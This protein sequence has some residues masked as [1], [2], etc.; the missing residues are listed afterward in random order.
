M[1]T[2]AQ[3]VTPEQAKEKA[4][5]F[6]KAN[7]ARTGGKRSAPAASALKTAVVFDAKDMAGQPY[8][9]AVSATQHDGFVLVSGDERFKAVLGYSDVSNFDEQNMPDNMRVFLQGYIDEMKYLESINYQ[10]TKAAPRRS[11]S[12]VG[13]LMTTTW[14]QRAPYN[15]QCPLD[16]SQRSATGCVATAMAQVVNYHIQNDHGP[17]ATIAEIP[18]YTI[19]NT[20]ITVSAIP[21]G[22]A[23]PSKD[24]LLNSYANNAGT[25]EQK[26]AVAQLMYYCGT[27]V[28]M[29]YAAGSSGTQTAYVANALINYFGFDNT[30]RFVRR[31]DYSYADWVNLIYNEVAASRPVVLGAGRAAGGHAFVADGFDATNTLFHI[32]WG[33]GGYLD[34][35]F[36][37]S[38]LN[39]DD[40]G[41]TGAAAGTDGYTIDQQAIVGI[42]HV[43]ASG[44]TDPASLTMDSYRVAG[45][46]IHFSAGNLTGTTN[47][48]DIGV[49]VYDG[50]SI[51]LFKLIASQ[52][53]S[54]GSAFPDV[55]AS[56]ICADFANQTRKLIPMSRVSE[57]STW[58]PGADPDINYFSAVYDAYGVP[59]LTAHPAPNFQNTTFS[60]P[61]TVFVNTPQY[62]NV[63]FTNNGEEYYGMAYFFVSTDANNKGAF[64]AQRGLGAPTGVPTSVEFEWTPTSATT[65]YI[66]AT[67]DEA[68]TNVVG[69]TSVTATTDASLAGKTL[70]IVNYQLE[71]QDDQSFQIDGNGTRS[72]DVYGSMLKGKVTIKN[73]SASNYNYNGK[74]ITL[75]YKKWN[76]SQF[77]M[78]NSDYDIGVLQPSL[79]GG[80]EVTFDVNRDGLES[81]LYQIS[82][83]TF[84]IVGGNVQNRT[85]LDERYTINLKP[86]GMTIASASDWETFCTNVNGGN[87][88]SGQLVKMTA[89]ITT[90]TRMNGIFKGVFDG[91]GHTL[92]I[93]ISVTDGQSYC[94]PFKSI[95]GA[96]I[97]NLTVT[98]SVT[99]NGQFTGGLVG[100]MDGDN[101][102]IE[103]CVVNANVTLNGYGGGVVGSLDESLTIK[104]VVY[105]GTITQ[106]KNNLTGGII[107]FYNGTN[108]S[109]TMTNCLFKGTYSGPSTFHPIGMKYNTSSPFSTLSCTNCF[110]TANPQNNP[111]AGVVIADGTKVSQ[112]SLGQGISILSGSTCSFLNEVYHYGTVT[113][114]YNDPEAAV[115]YSL[116][117]TPLPG[118][119]FTIS[120]DDAAFDDG[121][122]T[123]T[124]GYSFTISYNLDGGTVATPNPT[125]YT[126][127]SSDITLNNPTRE[128]WTFT[129]WTGTGLNGAQM[130]V[131]IAQGSTGHR[132]YTATWTA[133]ELAIDPSDGAYVINNKNDWDRFCALVN[134]G[135]NYWSKTVKLTADIGTAQDPVTTK[136]GGWVEGNFK[137][138]QA[139]FDGQGHTLTVNYFDGAPFQGT[140]NATIRNLHVAGNITANSQFAAG[141]VSEAHYGLTIENC[142]SS[143]AIS[144]SVSGDGTH[145]GLVGVLYHDNNSNVNITGCVFDGSITTTNGTNNCGGFIGWSYNSS[146][147]TLSN[148]VLAPTSVSS[149]MLEKTFVRYNSDTAPT[150][151]NTY[152]VHVDNLTE[153]QGKEAHTITAGENV[154]SVA[155]GG[156]ATEYNVSG[157]TAYEGSNGLKYGSTVYAGI[158][159]AVDLALTANPP[160]NYIVDTYT[161]SAGSITT[162]S[163]TSA[164]L[165]MPNENVTIG[166]T[167]KM[168]ELNKDNEN[169]YLVE[170]ANDW[171]LFCLRVNNGLSTYS[172]ATVKLTANI[173]TTQDPVTTMAGVFLYDGDNWVYRRFEGTF[174]GQGNT[175]T[176]GYGTS[177]NRFSEQYA[178]PFRYV[179]GA[180]IRNLHVAGNIYTSNQCAT[181]FVGNVEELPITLTNCRS[182]V[183]INCNYEYSGL[184]AGFVAY[185]PH[186]LNGSQITGC[187]FDGSFTTIQKDESCGGFF[188][189]AGGSI[190]ITNCVV[191][192]G[193]VSAGMLSNTFGYYSETATFNNCYYVP[194]EN[195]PTTQGTAAHTIS[196]GTNVTS[197]AIS[198]T[199]TTTYNVSGI[200][201]YGAGKGIMVGNDVCAVNGDEVALTLALSQSG[202]TTT[203]TASAGTLN[204]TD[205]THATLT[206]PNEN[207][208]IGAVF[209][210]NASYIDENGIAQT[211][212]ANELTSSDE[213]LASG[214]YVVSEDVAFSNR[215][216]V[217]GTVNLIL[218]D[219]KT[220]TASAG[221]NVPENSSL[222]I[223]GQSSGTGKL[224]AQPGVSNQAAI[225]GGNEGGEGVN[226]SAGTITIYGGKVTATSWAGAG[227]GGG[228]TYVEGGVF[229]GSSGGTVNIYGGTVTAQGGMGAAIGGS[230]G[231]TGFTVNIYGGTI[232][233]TSGATAAA[234]GGGDQSTGGTVNIHGGNI[235]ANAIDYGGGSTDGFGIG[236]GPSYKSPTTVNLSWT[237]TTDRITATSYNGTV[238]IADGKTL[239]DGANYY[240]G[241]LT[242]EQLTAMATQTLQPFVPTG[243]TL[244]TVGEDLTATFD[245]TSLET[246]NIPAPISVKRVTLNRTFSADKASTVM[247]PFDYTCNNN[248]GGTFYRFVGVEKENNTWV[249]TM[250]ATGDGANNAG[251][252]TANMPYLFMP[253]GTSITFTIPSEGVTLNTTGGGNKQTADAGSHWTFKGT[254]AYKEWIAD[255]ANS[256]EI[257]SVYGFA[258][259]QKEGINVGDFV[260]V[261]SGAKI[262]P[263]CAYLI[264]ND[265]PNSAP[266][267]RATEELPQSIV[268][269]L[270]GANGTV[271][272]IGTLDTTTGD[273]TFDSDA[274]YDMS[275][276]KLDGKPTTKGLY[277]NNGRKVVIK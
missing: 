24:L 57:T 120:K 145:G 162:N 125:T 250:Q 6:L 203:Y 274:W 133:D 21:S 113:L 204:Q 214:W 3:H 136:A 85:E 31:I 84:E 140:I 198:T 223:W 254:Y 40:A 230:S 74:Y 26:A 182:S 220:L 172:G 185:I 19:P 165:T 167:W 15:N 118:N 70:A 189:V 88:Y 207:V 231:C 277:I 141:F 144:S 200:K 63:T 149:G 95:E 11:M 55:A 51:T 268:V 242:S 156:T 252:L 46:D 219:G 131:T 123:I 65:Y 164:T 251:T 160:T 266:R 61:G 38:V 197:L 122:A 53:L 47:S 218:A 100:F 37:L 154:S 64:V 174:D 69:S 126:S 33:W 105:G 27:S 213:A 119:S 177:E 101:N 194:V 117:G 138:F 259:V 224:T 222:I 236:S 128:G 201:F 135:N 244:A 25:D 130:T 237:N 9:Y 264:W 146:L 211:H 271:T 163:A 50:S 98:G 232:N 66:W 35:Y 114:G 89:D 186:G 43:G 42:Q 221:V 109:L 151:T 78:L 157:I 249:A 155:I 76:G 5:Q 227:I 262:R 192:P 121:T 91:G 7:Y 216:V 269:K 129:G 32:N 170:N 241:T 173:G 20:T 139:S 199:P 270:I 107:G 193:S 23:I 267:H 225:G 8:L 258:G 102:L 54:T 13:V 184:H 41:Q 56:A 4:S 1:G 132:H 175:L 196:A 202:Y 110:Y 93:T 180:T 273:V 272:G 142:R 215:I 239:T 229:H 67:T 240:S 171:D 148:S 208:T 115:T 245:G 235:T 143:V 179:K 58:I 81:G 233:A 72:I 257:G 18:G 137:D 210:F 150:I 275:G 45:T 159:D 96:T 263:M 10:P 92:N 106:N 34:D 80:A 59:T 261:K 86:I 2:W 212:G 188:A 12:N 178:A 108:K 71:G 82:L 153:N 48:F 206:M 28:K 166:V 104:D 190:T 147:T 248:E 158:S 83:T 49:G 152:Y 176:V 60:I 265:T 112:L 22:T 127:A 195:L 205:D 181:G 111:D 17:A 260:K 134:S 243:V 75:T 124:A 97:K 276:R 14:N 16:N 226:N 256:A 52:S 234:I 62:T 90:S 103:N 253:T 168:R 73:L 87:S 228:G 99:S 94:A 169:N 68:G 79:A 217:S 187:L 161:A 29:H 183:N 39:P 116:D 247:L 44:T 30:T 209:L 191:K 255:G 238:T 246:V 36:A 77:V